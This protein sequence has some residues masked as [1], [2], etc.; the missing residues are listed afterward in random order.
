MNQIP[1]CASYTK[2]IADFLL[3]YQLPYVISYNHKKFRYTIKE[4]KQ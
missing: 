3:V 2:K 4:V 1:H